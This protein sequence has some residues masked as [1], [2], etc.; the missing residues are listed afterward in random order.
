ML[1]CVDVY[2]VAMFVKGKLF[3]QSWDT[4]TSKKSK[5]RG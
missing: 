5:W 2:S 3:E 1:A 4:K